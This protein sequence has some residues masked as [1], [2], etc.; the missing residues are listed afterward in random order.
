MFVE[1]ILQVR[2]K[3]KRKIIVYKNLYGNRKELEATDAVTKQG[4]S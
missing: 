1:K 3:Q 4:L 2:R